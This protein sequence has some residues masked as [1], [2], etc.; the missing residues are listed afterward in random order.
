MDKEQAIQD[1]WSRFGWQAFAENSLPT[2]ENAPALPFI[3]YSVSL[4][5][6]G[7]PVLLTGTLR[8]RNTSWKRLSNKTEE[9]ADYLDKIYPIKITKGYM[10]LTPGSPFAQRMSGTEDDMEKS[11]LINLQAEFLTKN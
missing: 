3:T 5:S 9:I 6:I 10:Y 4:D 1:F 11:V 2:G 7:S 8:D